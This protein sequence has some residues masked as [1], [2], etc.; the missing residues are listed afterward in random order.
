MHLVDAGPNFFIVLNV[1]VPSTWNAEMHSAETGTECAQHGASTPGSLKIQRLSVFCF[2]PCSASALVAYENES[3]V[4]RL[5]VC[6][7]SGWDGTLSPVNHSDASQ[8]WS[9]VLGST[10]SR[11][12]CF[13]LR[14]I[15]RPVKLQ[16]QQL[17]KMLLASFTRLWRKP[18][19]SRSPVGSRHTIKRSWLVG[20]TW[21]LITLWRKLTLALNE[22]SGIG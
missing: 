5:R 12:T 16:E 6:S 4:G 17:R 7:V 15:H 19:T 20:G 22:L 18:N 14:I 1:F 8:S 13:P 11:V 9:S 21:Q 2:N 3:V 10:C